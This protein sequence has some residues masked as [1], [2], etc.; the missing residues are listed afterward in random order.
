MKRDYC[1]LFPEGVWGQCCKEHDLAILDF[2]IP[3]IVHNWNLAVCINASSY[4][5]KVKSKFLVRYIVPTA[6]FIGTSTIGYLWRF[7]HWGASKL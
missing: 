6:V 2:D 5:V 7:Y 1:T 4:S 3:Y